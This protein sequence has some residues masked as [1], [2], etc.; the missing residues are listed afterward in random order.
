MSETM[1]IGE[2]ARQAGLTPDTVR[3]YEKK[4]LLDGRHMTRRDNNYKEYGSQALAR[5]RL[6]SHAKCAGFTLGEIV[7]MLEEWH[8]LSEGERHALFTDK[9]AQIERRI[10]GLAEMKDYL[11]AAMPVCL[12]MG[13]RGKGCRDETGS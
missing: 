12:L 8:K 3:F 2:L 7:Q 6:I 4:G 5:L 10:A 11:S 1:L 9:I 13:G